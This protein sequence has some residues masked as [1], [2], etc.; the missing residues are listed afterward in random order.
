MDNCST[1]GGNCSSQTEENFLVSPLFTSLLSLFLLL[2]V[3][4]IVLKVLTASAL[5][6]RSIPIHKSVRILLF[7]LL[8]AE[9]LTGIVLMMKT[10]NS[11]ILSASTTTPSV[12]PS[13]P[14]CRF[15][16]WAFATLLPARM[17]ALTTYSTVVFIYIR[18]GKERIRTGYIVVA[19]VIIWLM[20]AALGVDRW[21][22]ES[23]GVFYFQNVTCTPISSRRLIVPLRASSQTIWL[24]FGGI[25]PF[26]VSIAMPIA[27]YCQEKRYGQHCMMPATAYKKSVVRLPTFLLIGNTCNFIWMIVPA[28]AFSI[29]NFGPHR[30]DVEAIVLIFFT[31]LTLSLLPTPVFMLCYLRTLRNKVREIVTCC[32]CAR[33]RKRKSISFTGNTPAYRTTRYTIANPYCN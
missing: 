10:I 21:V 27:A 17:F 24:V 12:V 8:L 28:L 2:D 18:Y 26:I 3:A 20:A 4:A 14:L 32:N 30:V 19:L 15:I 11:A 29:S 16:L 31:C 5:T 22:A 1:E 6:A 7:N 25:I 33:C 13:L 23:L 9:I